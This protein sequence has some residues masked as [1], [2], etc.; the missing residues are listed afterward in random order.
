MISF[1][2]KTFVLRKNILCYCYLRFGFLSW[3][4]FND[5]SAHLSF[6][7]KLEPLNHHVALWEI[8]IPLY[9][10]YFSGESKVQNFYNF[11][12]NKRPRRWHHISADRYLLVR[13][14][15]TRFWYCDVKWQRIEPA[16]ILLLRVPISKD[17]LNSAPPSSSVIAQNMWGL[18]WIVWS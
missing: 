5:Y 16:Y 2:Y 4:A 8:V 12:K 10:S 15:H 1:R 6:P 9:P 13:L 3:Y 7:F 11:F 14:L 17:F 18:Q